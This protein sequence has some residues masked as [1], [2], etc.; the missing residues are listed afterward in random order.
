MENK[1]NKQNEVN[2]QEQEEILQQ[3]QKMIPDLLGLRKKE[4]AI[5]KGIEDLTNV[6]KLRML[7]LLMENEDRELAIF[8]LLG[9]IFDVD[10]LCDYV[11]LILA[12]RCSKGGWRANQLVAIASE[13]RKEKAG[14]MG[15][16]GRIFRRKEKEP[17][18]GEVET[19]E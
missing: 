10:F 11:D 16:F 8:Y 13:K 18:L 17:P 5:A 9:E 4:D 19:I 7:S 6:E 14:I 3:L 1:E 2:E 12:F 15:F